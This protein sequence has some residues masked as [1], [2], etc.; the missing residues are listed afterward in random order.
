M[1][2][3]T[4]KAGKEKK[5]FSE[6]PEFKQ[7]KE[8]SI[9]LPTYNEEGGI[10]R[11][12]E[13][14]G[15]VLKGKYDYEIVIVDDASK[16]NTPEIIDSYD[17]DEVAALHRHNIKGIFSALHDGV[18]AA[19]SNIV[20][21][22]DAD[23]SHPPAKISEMLTYIKEAD[24][25]SCSRFAKG[26]GLEMPA[27]KKLAT[28]SLNS[29]LRLILGFKITDF[30][31]GFHAMKRDKFLA[32][33]FK[34]PSVWGEFDMELFYRAQKRGYVIKEIP[35]IYRYREEGK[36]KSESYIKYA[37]VYWKR[38]LQLKLIG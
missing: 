12:I 22:M 8:V 16:D 5:E 13:S 33:S 1:K 20:V 36:S 6:I 34:Y 17:G 29:C 35:F 11:M 24:I 28:F 14:I 31:G 23:F 37:F 30:T 27:F 38:A 26:A 18:K 32:L 9:I 2:S 19:R 10:K 25:V 3:Y 15:E 7:E 4:Y 21:I